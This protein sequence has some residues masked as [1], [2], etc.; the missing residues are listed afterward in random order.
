MF[1]I[2]TIAVLLGALSGIALADH[3]PQ[4]SYPMTR[5]M[6]QR[7]IELYNDRADLARLYDLAVTFEGGWRFFDPRALGRVD[8]RVL[9]MFDDQIA[10]SNRE[11]ARDM[12]EGNRVYGRRYDV[13]GDSRDG[14]FQGGVQRV[15]GHTY[16]QERRELDELMRLRN[17]FLTYRG[18]FDQQSLG[19]KWNIVQRLVQMEHQEVREDQR[20]L[21]GQGFQDPMQGL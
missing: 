15:A 16:G 13:Q 21:Q 6:Y 9:R 14:R 20:W 18:R 3:L 19:V 4:R 7:Q 1:R 17:Q 10:E 12:R 8:E 2:A 5:E 11:L